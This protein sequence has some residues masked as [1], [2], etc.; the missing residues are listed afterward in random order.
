MFVNGELNHKIYEV[1]FLPAA[2]VEIICLGTR[3]RL[4]LE[5]N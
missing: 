3:V 4:G 1:F 2:M 5:L